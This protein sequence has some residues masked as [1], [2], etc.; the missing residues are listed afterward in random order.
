MWDLVTFFFH[1]IKLGLHNSTFY[2]KDQKPNSS[3]LDYP[4]SNKHSGRVYLFEGQH[5]Q[6]LE[7]LG[8]QVRQISV[9][10]ASQTRRIHC[11]CRKG[12]SRKETLTWLISSF[13]SWLS[14]V[15]TDVQKTG[16][17]TEK[18]RKA[19]G[20]NP[21][22]PSQLP[23]EYLFLNIFHLGSPKGS[24]TLHAQHF[25]HSLLLQT[26]LS[27]INSCLSYSQR[28]KAPTPTGCQPLLPRWVKYQCL[29]RLPLRSLSSHTTS[30][31][32]LSSSCHHSSPP[33]QQK[34]LNDTLLPC[35]PFPLFF[36][37]QKWPGGSDGK[38]SA[39]N[40]ETQ[41]WSLG[42]EDPLEKGMPTHSSILAWRIPWTE[43]PGRLQSMG[44][45]RVRHD[46]VTNTLKNTTLRMFL[47]FL[48]LPWRLSSKDSTCQCRRCGF[49]S[50]VGMTPW[51]RK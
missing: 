17:F 45:Q 8:T 48:G 21:S 30:H 38:E 46:W 2:Y 18:T 41:V 39:C 22:F 49:D 51:R 3:I 26:H 37:S 15:Y 31:L 23:S 9:T 33:H 5:I 13:W 10:H 20:H 29:A 6:L 42:W 12:G 35:Q 11:W 16:R 28:T 14:E 32:S 47:H 25:L 40:R 19:E 34:S 44:S 4:L 27:S 50:W 1:N 36:S 7:P 43:E 24:H